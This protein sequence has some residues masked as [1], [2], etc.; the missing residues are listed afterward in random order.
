MLPCPASKG[1]GV[2]QELEGTQPGQLAQTDQRDI[3]H[4]VALCLAMTAGGKEEG[5]MLGVVAFVFPR[6]HEVPRS[7]AFQELAEHLPMD[8]K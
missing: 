1:L 8:G 6:N 4:H 3:P 5:G 2:H 7:P